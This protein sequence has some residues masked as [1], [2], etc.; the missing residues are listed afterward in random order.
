[1]QLKGKYVQPVTF[2]KHPFWNTQC[3]TKTGR[4]GGIMLSALCCV[5]SN[6]PKFTGKYSFPS[7]SL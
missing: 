7:Y 4:R 1:M 3:G 6:S 5:L 2:A